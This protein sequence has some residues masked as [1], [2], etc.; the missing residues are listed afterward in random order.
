MTPEKQKEI[1]KQ[2]KEGK[3]KSYAKQQKE[4]HEKK[5]EEQVRK[6]LS[7]PEIM[8]KLFED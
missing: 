4:N 7:D 8:K 6:V 5:L 1:A 2:I 3:I